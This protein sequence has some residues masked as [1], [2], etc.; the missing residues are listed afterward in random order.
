MPPPL[1]S[2]S[3]AT[4]N[5]TEILRTL[6]ESGQTGY[7]KMKSGDQEG[8]VA[9][10]NGVIVHAVAGTHTGLHALFQFV[11]WR[12]AHFEFHERPIPAT[13][14][15]DLVV[16]DAKVLLDGVAFKEEEQHLLHQ[17]P[18]GLET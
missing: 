4:F 12:E 14:A 15:R 18:G 9:L 3:S 1:P 17:S 11:G 5:L 16:Y 13:L 2:G 7:L 10:E 6:V 8:F